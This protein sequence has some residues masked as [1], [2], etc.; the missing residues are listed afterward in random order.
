M[1]EYHGILVNISQK[2]KA[3][4][5]K[6]K[7]LGKKKTNDGKWILYRIGVASEKI[8]ETI[9]QLQENM[10]KGFYFLYVLLNHFDFQSQLLDSLLQEELHHLH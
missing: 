1:D 6:L 2:D 3:I 9:K 10:M 8:N 5:N 7:I 4:F